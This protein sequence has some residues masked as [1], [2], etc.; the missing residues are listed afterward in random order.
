MKSTDL[1]I[2][3]STAFIFLAI[4]ACDDSEAIQEDSMKFYYAETFCA[5]PWE[6]TDVST[7][8]ALK[9]QVSEYLTNLDIIF[10]ELEILDGGVEEVCYAC[11]CTSGRIIEVISTSTYQNILLENGFKLK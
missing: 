4:M 1:K 10:Y 3:F 9:I 6:Q 5:D 2:V 11:S 8:E 7:D